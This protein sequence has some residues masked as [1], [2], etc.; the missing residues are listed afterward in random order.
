MQR[1][2]NIWLNPYNCKWSKLRRCLNSMEIIN[3]NQPIPLQLRDAWH[4]RHHRCMTLFRWLSLRGRGICT[5]SMEITMI[6]LLMLMFKATHVVAVFLTVVTP[7]ISRWYCKEDLHAGLAT[8]MLWSPIVKK[9]EGCT[10]PLRVIIYNPL[11]TTRHAKSSNGRWQPLQLGSVVETNPWGNFLYSLGVD[12]VLHKVASSHFHLG[13]QL[14]GV[15]VNAGELRIQIRMCSLYSC[16]YQSSNPWHAANR[17]N[18]MMIQPKLQRTLGKL[19][20]SLAVMHLACS[21]CRNPNQLCNWHWNSQA[22][23][24]QACFSWWHHSTC[25]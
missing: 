11:C 16:I 20:T 6:S 1:T 21:S 5:I 22:S 17:T 8:T 7:K 19:K 23:Q 14:L 18:R 25:K 13:F 2:K 9:S 12:W 4:Y 10:W 3:I 15:G 24:E